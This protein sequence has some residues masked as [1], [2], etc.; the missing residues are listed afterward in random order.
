MD[1][2][3]INLYEDDVYKKEEPHEE[4]VGLLVFRLAKEWYAVPLTTAKEVVP[5]EKIAYLPSVQ[6]F[7]AGIIN[8]RGNILAVTDC[9]VIFDLPQSEIT[10]KTRIVVIH[11]GAL[12]TGLLVDEVREIVNVPLS[13]IAPPL[14]TIS[15][16]LIEYFKGEYKAKDHLIA[17]LNVDKILEKTS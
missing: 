7:V 14:A 16:S 4:M 13:A 8:L 6:P 12:E 10:D 15:G 11:S 5:V 3:K 1:N 17:V 9:K 2:L